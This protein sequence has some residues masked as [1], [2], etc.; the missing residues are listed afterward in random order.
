MAWFEEYVGAP[1]ENFPTPP[2]SFNCGELVRYVMKTRLGI[3]SPPV[4]A[5]GKKLREC[6]ANMSVPEAYGLV[7]Y[8][9]TE[10][11]PYDI[12]YLMRS[13]RRDH[14]AIAVQASQG[15]M[16]LHCLQGAGVVL[17]SEF[18]L[19]ANSF[20]SFME[21]RRHKDVTKEMVTCRA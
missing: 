5:D 4:L 21:W 12:V 9:G 16:F 17:E 3:G 11:W 14:I 10:R 6:I 18:E 15:L 13:V 2:R 1:W 19:K 8:E 7:P 20:S